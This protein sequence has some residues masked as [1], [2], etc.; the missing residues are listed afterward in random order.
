MIVVYVTHDNTELMSFVQLSLLQIQ[1]EAMGFPYPESLF[2]N[3]LNTT[4]ELHN[5]K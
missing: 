4:H 1:Y 5:V 3:L 2:S